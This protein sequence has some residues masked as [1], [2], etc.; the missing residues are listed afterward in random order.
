L[1]NILL[2][3]DG[4]GLAL[5]AQ[6]RELYSDVSAVECMDGGTQGLALLGHLS[7]R[8]AL[9][10]LDAFSEG[11]APGEISVLAK[12]E[13]LCVRNTQGT[14]SHE[15]NAGELLAA[16]QLIGDLP[17]QVFL[18]GV[19]PERLRTEIGLSPTVNAALPMALRCSHEIVDR[20]LAGIGAKT[21][22]AVC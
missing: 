1:G 5:L 2:G 4:V 18:I 7:G 8:K 13:I 11:R 21:N 6:V 19:E 3:D 22:L 10:L 17:E 9:V 20:A 12:T 14:T 15:G 16:A